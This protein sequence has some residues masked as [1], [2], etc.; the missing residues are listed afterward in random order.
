[1][2]LV[3]SSRT[4]GDKFRG[5]LISL[6]MGIKAVSTPILAG[7]IAFTKWRGSSTLMWQLWSV[8]L[9]VKKLSEAEVD[10]NSSYAGLHLGL[11]LV[12]A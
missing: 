2:E 9:P 7:E 12:P 4:I 6:G 11:L 3:S 5:S 10:Y 8:S 1:M